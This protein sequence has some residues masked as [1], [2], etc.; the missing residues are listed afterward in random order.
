MIEN[1]ALN[2]ILKLPLQAGVLICCWHHWPFLPG[3]PFGIEVQAPSKLIFLAYLAK[4]AF[5]EKK[6]FQT[7]VVPRKISYRSI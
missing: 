5:L 6:R 4:F 2:N 1:D 7:E 3:A